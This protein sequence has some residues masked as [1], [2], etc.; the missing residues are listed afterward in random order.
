MTSF[1]TTQTEQQIK[2]HKV[3][4]IQINYSWLKVTT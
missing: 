4:H 3:M 1:N 2:Y